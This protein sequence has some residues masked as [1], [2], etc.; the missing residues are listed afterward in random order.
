[1]CGVR[2]PQ[3]RVVS[4]S[5]SPTGISRLQEN[6]PPGG[7]YSSPMPRD[8]VILW[9]WVFLMSEVPLYILEPRPLNPKLHT[10]KPNPTPQT[11]NPQPKP[12]TLNPTSNPPQQ[13]FVRRI[14]RVKGKVWRD[15]QKMGDLTRETDR[16]KVAP[17]SLNP[18]SSI[19][20][21]TPQARTPKSLPEG[22]PSPSPPRAPQRRPP[23]PAG[24]PRS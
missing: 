7:P 14:N 20:N 13:L 15:H 23:Q 9:G 12:H 3:P 2:P 21:Q 19:I 6:A 24:V 8:L 11:L 22:G 4:S 1:M 16:M 5:L 17:T 18:Q 10:P